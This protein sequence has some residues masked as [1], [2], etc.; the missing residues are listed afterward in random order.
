VRKAFKVAKTEKPGP[1][2]LE[3]PSDVM[4]QRCEVEP[5]NLLLFEPKYPPGGN[6]EIIEKAFNFIMAA[7]FPIMLI[8]NGVIRTGAGE[9]LRKFVEKFH[10]PVVSTYMGKGAIPEDHPQHLG[11]L[12]AFSE[13]VARRAILRADVVVAF[14]YDFTELPAAYWNK[15]QRRLMI[16]IDSTA[17]EIDKYY[18]VRYEI[19]GNINRT[20]LFMLEY[21]LTEPLE[22]R[23]RRIREIEEFKKEFNDH[24]YPVEESKALKPSDV[25]K[26]LNETL[27]D[28]TIVSVDVGDHKIW[29]SRCLISRRPRKYLVPNGLAAMGFSL[30]AAIAAKTIFNETPVLCAIGD[31]GF[32]MSFSELETVKR[33]KLAFPVLI[34][35]NDMLGQIYTKQRMTYGERTIGVSF[36]NPDFIKIAEAFGL[37][38]VKI[39]T[40]DELKNSLKEAFI[41]EKTTLI[42]VKVD[43]EETFKVIQKLGLTRPIH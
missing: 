21:K 2:H 34:F 13:D 40:K 39:E 17:A 42:D 37:D 19:V 38:G 8:G 16:H 12:G 3:L 4:S 43:R 35:D 14:G 22:K 41:S 36:K 32:A 33:L 10:L 11:V 6:L 27:S 25:V 15:G 23:Q 26:V 7:D 28:D 9:N 30:P 18:P 1:V 29:M 5:L 20:L 24:F 31:G